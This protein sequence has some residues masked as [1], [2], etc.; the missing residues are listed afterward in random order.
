M[1]KEVLDFSEYFQV[2]ECVSYTSCAA[3]TSIFISSRGRLFGCGS[4]QFAELAQPVKNNANLDENLNTIKI[5]ECEYDENNETKNPFFV[6]TVNGDHNI[7]ALTRDGK[8]FY[9]G[10]QLEINGRNLQKMRE[11]KTELDTDEYF[12]DIAA[13]YYDMVLL[14]SKYFYKYRSLLK[15]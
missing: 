9:C 7:I 12:I 6:K 15:N 3:Y 13:T 8:V 1:W 10:Y 14:S 5:R 11:F 4:N 2:G